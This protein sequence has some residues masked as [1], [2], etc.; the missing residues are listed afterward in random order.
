MRMIRSLGM[1]E[2]TP[3]TRPQSWGLFECPYC[4]KE[5][6]LRLSHRKR[7]KSC[8]CHRSKLCSQAKTIHG[9]KRRGRQDPLYGVLS[10]MIERCE[11]KNS[12]SYPRYGGRGISV[13]DEWRRDPAAF[14]L[15]AKEK[16]YRKGLE[17]DRI[18]NDG[19]YSPENCRWATHLENVRNSTRAVLDLEKVREMRRRFERGEKASALARDYGVSRSAAYAAIKGETWKDE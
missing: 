14:F 13:C 4:G 16:G 3:G 11:N 7:N 5:F 10:K 1:R 19:D 8:G 2:T 17:I 18:D 12:K 9:L 6:E 15:W